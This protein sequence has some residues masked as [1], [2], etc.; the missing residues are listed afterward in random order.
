M[1]WLC[2]DTGG[3]FDTFTA[4]QNI[5]RGASG[6]EVMA[7]ADDEAQDVNVSYADEDYDL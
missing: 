2:I 4:W 3:I 1:R 6:N 5:E 7:T